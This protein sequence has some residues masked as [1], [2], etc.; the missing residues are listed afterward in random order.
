DIGAVRGTHILAAHD[1]K[2]VYS[3]NK[4]GGYGNIIILSDNNY[5][6][7]YAHNKKNIVKKG[8][9]VK[10]GQKIAEVGSTGHAT[11]SHLHFEVRKKEPSGGFRA[12]NPLIFYTK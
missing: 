8:I 7:V 6:T 9:F 3:G 10:A 4:F 12:Y 11:G 1:A 5:L 2:V